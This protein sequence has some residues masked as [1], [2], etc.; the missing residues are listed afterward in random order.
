MDLDL[1]EAFDQGFGPEPAHRPVSDRLEAGHRAVRRR[2]LAGTVVTVAVAAAVGVG[3]VAVLGDGGHAPSQV[4]T[5]RT[6]AVSWD[7]GELARYDDVGN[8]EIRPD[9][10][11]LERIDSPYPPSAGMDR[12]VALA[13]DYQGEESWLLMSWAVHSDGEVVETGGGASP[14]GAAGS[15][16]EWAA[17]QVRLTMTP[18]PEDNDNAPGYLEFGDDGRLVSSH[19]IE[20][21]DQVLDPGFKDFVLQGEPSAAA[22]LQGPDGK[23]WYVAIRDSGGLDVIAV[24][25][26][27]GGPTLGDFVAYA[28]QRY[29]SGEGLR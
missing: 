1:R 21:L 29:A 7:E 22:L 11:V 23:K 12:S 18:T 20:I 27:T 19:D 10:T 15:L 9:A 3:A 24:P 13:L 8:L 4:A 14:G 25:F 6:P 28:R 5:D 26:K 2:R 16:A 17:E